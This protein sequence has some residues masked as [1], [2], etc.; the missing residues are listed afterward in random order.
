MAI[1]LEQLE[2]ALMTA[3]PGARFPV[4]DREMALQRAHWLHDDI[5]AWRFDLCLTYQPIEFDGCEPMH[6]P[7]Y[8]LAESPYSASK[9]TEDRKLGEDQ[10]MFHGEGSGLD[11][12]DLLKLSRASAIGHTVLKHTNW[13]HTHA[14][15]V[16]DPRD[17][18]AVIEEILWLGRWR[19]PVEVQLNAK[20][21]PGTGK[22]VDCRFRSEGITINLEVK[23]RPRTWLAGVD[24]GFGVQDL[25]SLFDGVGGKFPATEP[26]D[27]YNVVALTIVAP[28]DDL[29]R[30]HATQFLASHPE[31]AAVVVWSEHDPTAG[32]NHEFICRANGPGRLLEL[33]FK[34]D[35]E[36]RS[37]VGFI[38]HPVRHATERREMT[39]EESLRLMQKMAAEEN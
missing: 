38:R 22:D 37:R 8:R 23:Y 11:T 10:E 28:I 17:H 35:E 25:R 1:T 19:N 39:F 6:I 12:P 21:V 7:K 31:I 26:Q 13:P 15:R 24:G 33:L 4:L 16:R 20:L 30:H 29:L 36:E 27:A 34:S 2:R 9:G 32:R 5:Q 14:R 3:Y 18:I